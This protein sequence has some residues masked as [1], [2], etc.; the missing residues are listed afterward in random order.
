MLQI[1]V[2]SVQLLDRKTRKSIW[3]GTYSFAVACDDHKRRF[4]P[5][6]ICLVTVAKVLLPLRW[7]CVGSAEG[8]CRVLHSG[9]QG[10][11]TERQT[12]APHHRLP[13]SCLWSVAM[14]EQPFLPLFDTD[15][16][17]H[18]TL[19]FLWKSTIFTGAH[20]GVPVFRKFYIDVR[21][22]ERHGSLL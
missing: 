18:L 11:V 13:R 10:F 20:G 4:I 8:V 15:N 9:F 17:D 3:Y 16:C 1:L 6:I 12:P 2:I 22:F 5:V 19:L 21:R 14:G 7:R